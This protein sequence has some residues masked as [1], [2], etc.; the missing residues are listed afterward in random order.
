MARAAD[1]LAGEQDRA[2]AAAAT[3]FDDARDTARRELVAVA[4]GAGVVIVLLLITVQD[5]VRLALE[6]RDEPA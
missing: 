3:G 2:S 6:R 5:V 4:I 1:D